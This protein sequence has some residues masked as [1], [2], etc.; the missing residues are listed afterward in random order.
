M[1][2]KDGVAASAVRTT[3]L[4]PARVE[5]IA[6][7][8]YQK[9]PHFLEE[10]KKEDSELLALALQKLAEWLHDGHP[11][12]PT[13]PPTNALEKRFESFEKKLNAMA[14]A[15]PQQ[16]SERLA[17][18][19]S[20]EP[21][22]TYASMAAK[23]ASVTRQQRAPAPSQQRRQIMVKIDERKEAEETKKKPTSQV[24]KDLAQ[25]GVISARRLP[26]GDLVLHTT[27]QASRDRMARDST[28]AQKIAPSARV[29]CKTYPVMVHGV[30]ITFQVKDQGQAI[31]VITRDNARLH[32][33]LDVRRV[34]WPRSVAGKG[35]ARA[36]LIVELGTPEQANRVLDEGLLIG[37]EQFTAV[38]FDRDCRITQCF[39]CHRYGHTAKACRN[40][41]F[42]HRCG[43]A[44][45]DVKCPTG[46]NGKHCPSCPNMQHKPWTK[47]CPRR[48]QERAR[49]DL[50]WNSRPERFP[51]RPFAIS[52]TVSP[53]SSADMTTPRTV[54]SASAAT[55]ATPSAGSGPPFI[56]GFQLVMGGGKKRKMS[57]PP[58]AA[59][60]PVGRPRKVTAQ[61]PSQGRPAVPRTPGGGSQGSSQS[62]GSPPLA[63]AE[64]P[65]PPALMDFS[66]VTSAEVD[67]LVGQVASGQTVNAAT[68]QDEAL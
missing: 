8:A 63:R 1:G 60:K 52:R 21:P 48:Q 51:E 14:E 33:G 28:W 22:T 68:E 13:S 59:R 11:T 18:P 34:A 40:A 62:A 30:S 15:I 6:N 43:G 16:I 12:A 7:K 36:S 23:S 38:L 42:C 57:P 49:A 53:T 9:E 26:S 50:A 20:V 5:Y 37:T 55:T 39:K 66:P 32:Q 44:H 56:D 46:A 27:D 25:E 19:V 35:K 29:S 4:R 58:E 54:P 47:D 65:A 41:P 24:V 31:G 61:A 3:T 17:A 2:Q 10:M 67:A 45:S 64:A